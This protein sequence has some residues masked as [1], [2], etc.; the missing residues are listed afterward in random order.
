M[1]SEQKL[2]KL[3]TEKFG[4][5]VQLPLQSSALLTTSAEFKASQNDSKYDLQV[6]RE[7]RGMGDPR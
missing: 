2:C 4:S 1:W 7:R 3:N 6:V 5:P